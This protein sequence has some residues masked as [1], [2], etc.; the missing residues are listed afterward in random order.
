MTPSD[1]AHSTNL[2]YILSLLTD[3]GA[4]HRARQSR[5]QRNGRTK[6][7]LQFS[8]NAVSNHVCKMGHSWLRRDT[9]VH[10]VGKASAAL[11]IAEQ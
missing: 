4:G 9:V 1:A 2:Y 7:T 5:E 11:R 6:S 3:G 10:S 8:K